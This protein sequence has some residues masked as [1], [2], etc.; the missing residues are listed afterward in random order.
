MPTVGFTSTVAGLKPTSSA[1]GTGNTARFVQPGGL[2]VF[3]LTD[4]DSDRGFALVADTENHA[5]RRVALDGSWAVT[6]VAG[7]HLVSGAL[8]GTGD[9]ARFNKPSDVAVHPS[10]L[11]ALVTD[12]GNHALRR[13]SLNLLA[14]VGRV[15]TVAGRAPPR[16]GS[17][18]FV[19]GPGGAA[20]FFFPNSVTIDLARGFALVTDGGNHCVRRVTLGEH[21]LYPWYVSTAAGGGT[22]GGAGAAGAV[23]AAVGSNA[24]FHSPHGIALDSAAGFALVADLENHLIRHIDLGTWAVRTYAGAIGVTGFADGAGLTAARFSFPY[25]VA[26]APPAMATAF[27]AAFALV[28]DRG[29]RAV[30]L[31]NLSSSSS[32]PHVTTLTGQGGS[33]EPGFQ[34]G[35]GA[36]ARFVYTAGVALDARRGVGLVLSEDTLR[37]V[38]VLAPQ[39]CAMGAWNQTNPSSSSSSSSSGAGAGAAQCSL[40]CGG[41]TLER[42]R[43]VLRPAR[44]GGA[45]CGPVNGT[46]T[47]NTAPCAAAPLPA[48]GIGSGTLSAITCAVLAVVAL[49]GR[50]AL[51]TRRARRT[52]KLRA[53]AAIITA[54]KDMPACV[55]AQAELR[56]VEKDMHPAAGAA[57]ASPA[58]AA[59]DGTALEKKGALP[60]S[61]ILVGSG[62]AH[63]QSP[64]FSQADAN[65]D[66]VLCEAEF[67]AHAAM[68]A[69]GAARE[70]AVA[71][72]APLLEPAH[73]A[74][75]AR[76]FAAV[77]AAL[78]GVVDGA[79]AGVNDAAVLREVVVVVGAKVGCYYYFLSY[80]DLLTT[81][82]P[83]VSL[84]LLYLL[85]YLLSTRRHTASATASCR[86]T[87]ATRCSRRRRG[88]WPPRTRA[89][90]RQRASARR[91][92]ARATCT[93]CMR[94]AARRCRPFARR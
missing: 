70:V 43:V 94:T 83:L 75:I 45:P 12:W 52:V 36:A 18:G 9:G 66:G 71:V 79:V 30:R 89:W 33:A 44:Y 92:S 90:T 38:Q 28:S 6:T 7:R 62:R 72:G 69:V 58:A 34:D 13:V 42:W 87:P 51:R 74:V 32:A 57:A 49:M 11:Y 21:A 40:A 80:F 41:G 65:Q 91:G 39:H 64:A 55:N 16:G 68:A 8:D 46:T 17:L 26:I 61:A 67:E 53:A 3:Q 86:T 2:D 88:T 50:L 25:D 24:R 85:T 78:D 59:A 84:S 81:N 76:C 1:D 27:G 73:G 5:I 56:R 35:L 22:G 20:R 60:L 37:Q 4:G 63:R 10:G 31:L 77:R 47:C 29:N 93:S 23:D 48:A 15:T 19:N 14:D 54:P 82:L